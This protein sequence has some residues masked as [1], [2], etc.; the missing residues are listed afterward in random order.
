MHEWAEGKQMP[1]LE[2]EM[3]DKYLDVTKINNEC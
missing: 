1:E 2:K 3:L